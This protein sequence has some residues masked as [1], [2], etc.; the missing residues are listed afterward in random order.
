MRTS[1]TA[2]RFWLLDDSASTAFS[3]QRDCNWPADPVSFHHFVL[4]DRFS[5][6]SVVSVSEN[7]SR[8]F[9]HRQAF[10]PYCLRSS[11]PK[12]LTSMHSLRKR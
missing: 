1:A 12:S 10:S 9:P 6:L 8:W 7:P 5:V 11:G 4:S 3:R 2:V